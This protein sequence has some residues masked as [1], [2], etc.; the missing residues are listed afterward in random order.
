MTVRSSV[1]VRALLTEPVGATSS[2]PA[3][4][5]LVDER[6]CGSARRTLFLGDLF[7]TL[8]ELDVQIILEMGSF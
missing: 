6:T 1:H 7:V 8:E 4:S 3:T 5:R 2:L